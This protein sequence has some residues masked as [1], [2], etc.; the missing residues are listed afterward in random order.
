MKVVG[1]AIKTYRELRKITREAMADMLD[2]SVS[3]YAKIERGE[4]DLSITKLEKIAEILNV[5]ITQ[6]LKF[7]T[8]Q[9]FNITHNQTVQGTGTR[10]QS[11]HFHSDSH[12]DKYIKLLEAEV[13]RLKEEV[14]KLT[15]DS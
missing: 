1:D 13:E 2:M 14:K 6:I 8:N 5:D 15:R 4:T 12:L 9:I 7:D 11:V 10:A 3:G